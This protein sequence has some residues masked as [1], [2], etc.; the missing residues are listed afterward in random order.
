MTI[1]RMNLFLLPS[2]FLKLKDV[3][4]KLLNRYF[5]PTKE[6][7]LNLQ[8]STPIVKISKIS[9]WVSKMSN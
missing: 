4:T 9:H 1:D 8:R 3:K 2:S 7:P 6:T 5:T